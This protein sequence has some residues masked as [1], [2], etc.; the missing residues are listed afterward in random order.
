MKD[1]VWCP[2]RPRGASFPQPPA[3]GG[4]AG[5]YFSA[6]PLALRGVGAGRGAAPR[7]SAP[8]PLVRASPPRPAPRARRG[9]GAGWWGARG[10]GPR[11]R[12]SPL[13]SRSSPRADF[14]V[15]PA[16]EILANYVICPVRSQSEIKGAPARRAAGSLSPPCVGPPSGGG[17][18]NCI[19]NKPVLSNH[20][21]LMTG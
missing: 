10:G 3:G 4:R 14:P 2:L 19:S 6:C 17:T 20:D 21:P 18:W 7:A 13:A 8:P 1:R 5:G 15:F 11:G 12:P 16:C 9:L